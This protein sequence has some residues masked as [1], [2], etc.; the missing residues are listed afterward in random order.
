MSLTNEQVVELVKKNPI[1]IGCG[2]LS[3]ALLITA[4]IR[5]DL[6]AEEQQKLEQKTSEAD[7]IAA[8]LKNAA[9]LKEQMDSLLASHKQ[10]EGRLIQAKNL[11]ANSQYFYRLESETG[12][13][14]LDLRQSAV[15]AAAKKDMKGYLPTVFTVNVQG[16]YAQ[17]LTFLRRLEN[18]A[19]YCRVMT[20]SCNAV[21]AERG[22]VLTMALTLE[23]LG[24]P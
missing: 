13:K 12:V 2:I 22:A 7:R 20:A 9:Q 15:N 21:G 8:N 4:Y 23:L 14:L 1:S 3:L 5:S 11:M 18:G 24:Q 19:H 6:P 10:I 17:L 16:D